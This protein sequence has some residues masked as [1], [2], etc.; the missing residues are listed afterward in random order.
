MKKLTTF[1]RILTEA[2]IAFAEIEKKKIACSIAEKRR[3][4]EN[5]KKGRQEEYELPR[6]SACRTHG[7]PLLK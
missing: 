5:R 4:E 1:E 3:R 2:T 6:T 7:I